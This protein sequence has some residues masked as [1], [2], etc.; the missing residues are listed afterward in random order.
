MNTKIGW[1][2]YAEN[3]NNSTNIIEKI[4]D[5]TE[6]CTD[7]KYKKPV[8]DKKRM[9]INPDVAK[10]LGN[11][12][13]KNREVYVE[14]YIAQH[15]ENMCNQWCVGANSKESIDLVY[16]KGDSYTL[17]ELKVSGLNDKGTYTPPF[18]LVEIIKNYYLAKKFSE[19]V[20]VNV[21]INELAILST[22]KLIGTKIA[23]IKRRKTCN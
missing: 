19:N 14:R 13:E 12:G 3:N 7:W 6:V 15:D 20:K 5:N 10:K 1:K 2:N 22:N 11:K 16:K 17:I 8:H 9:K 18:A 4:K 23:H 21:K